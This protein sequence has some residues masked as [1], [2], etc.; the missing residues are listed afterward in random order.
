MT[1][2]QI[3][4]YQQ[5]LWYVNSLYELSIFDNYKIMDIIIS[6]ST[7]KSFIMSTD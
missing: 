4:N 2:V 7:I 5:I 1:M 6:D 3:C